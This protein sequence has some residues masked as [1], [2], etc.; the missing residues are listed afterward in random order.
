V[1]GADRRTGRL[2][3]QVTAAQSGGVGGAALAH[4]L[5]EQA[6]GGRQADGGAQAPG[7]GGRRDRDA[8]A[9]RR[10]MRAAGQRIGRGAQDGPRP[11]GSPS[12]TTGVPIPASAPSWAHVI[13][14]PG[15]AST[16]S[17]AASTWSS[18]PST[19]P[20]SRSPAAYTSTASP[21]TLRASV[22]TRPAPTTT[23]L[24]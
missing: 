24:P 13:A 22:R 18:R 3:D 11:A 21:S 10:A 7:D 5:H 16:A 9:A 12:A 17:N 19:R 2:D 8:Q 23:P 15:P 20:A 4:A 6:V 1:D 14:S